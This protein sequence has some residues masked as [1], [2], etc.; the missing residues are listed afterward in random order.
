M[1]RWRE[2]AFSVSSNDGSLVEVDDWDRD[3]EHRTLLIYDGACGFCRR[4]ATYAQTLVGEERL[5]VGAGGVVGYRFDELSHEDLERTVWAADQHGVLRSG[6]AAIF[7]VLAMAPGYGLFWALYRWLPG[8]AWITEF[9][10]RQVAKRRHHMSVIVRWLWGE[11]LLPSS[12]QVST[13][14]FV[15]LLGLVYVFAFASL[16][17]QLPGLVGEQGILPLSDYLARAQA[18]WGAAALWFVPTLGWFLP[19]GTGLV[20][21]AW[22]GALAGLGI[23]AGYWPRL[24]ALVCWLLHLSL[25]VAGQKF[26]Y[27]QWD[28]LLCEAGFIALFLAPWRT[29]LGIQPLTGVQTLARWLALWLV[30]RLVFVSA[31][32]KLSSGDAAWAA[33][34]ALEVHYQTQPLPNTLAYYLHQLPAWLHKMSCYTMFVV[35]F[36]APCMLLAPRRLRHVGAIAIV[37]LMSTIALSGNYGYFNLLT[38]ALALLALD[39]RLWARRFKGVTFNPG[40]RARGWQLGLALTLFT[41]TLSGLERHSRT[42]ILAPLEPLKK[43][44]APLRLTANYGLFAV[45]TM[46]RPELV[47][48]GSLDGQTWVPYELPYKPGRL[49]RAPAQVAPHMP[50]LDWQLWFAAL[51]GVNHNRWLV[52]L[53][54]GLLKDHQPI[55]RL[56]S[57]N[58]FD[59]PPKQLRIRRYRYEFTQLG[60]ANWWRREPL[61]MYL[62]AVHLSREN[63][64]VFAQPVNRMG[65]NP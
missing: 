16:A 24:L 49:D 35:E 19:S 33:C 63:K 20:A 54:E 7:S 4:W 55:R 38:A 34:S 23:A 17:V 46:D 61:G 60:E 2:W 45:M 42:T 29:K 57:Q 8:F 50:R 64:V 5:A 32:V 48:E 11:T 59:G 12:Y 47:I 51:G 36:A 9:G 6:A 21:I 62:K 37:V 65:P 41:L 39:D 40:Q 18:H 15:R 43:L 3:Q 52:G 25:V 58:P 56:F 14:F 31:F 44:V 30:W 13:Q 28:S 53:L 27:Y 10:Y 26:L 22:V 1:V